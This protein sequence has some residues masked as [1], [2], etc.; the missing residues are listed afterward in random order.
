MLCGA[1]VLPGLEG[2]GSRS[3]SALLSSSEG[4]EGTLLLTYP[5]Q[6]CMSQRERYHAY[7]EGVGSM[8]VYLY[9]KPIGA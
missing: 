5:K 2:T 3:L 4:L 9:I 1:S 8:Y 7:G 6:E